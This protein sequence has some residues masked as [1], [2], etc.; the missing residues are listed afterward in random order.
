MKT[1][2]TDKN[3]VAMKRTMDMHIDLGHQNC[4]LFPQKH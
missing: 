4:H 3:H 2:S 1:A